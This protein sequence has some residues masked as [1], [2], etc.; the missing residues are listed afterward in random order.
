MENK[1]YIIY[2]S[3]NENYEQHC[4]EVWSDNEDEK[5]Y[6]RVDDLTEYPE[7]ATIERDLFN[8]YDFIKAVRL[9]FRI[10]QRGYDNIVVKEVPWEIFQ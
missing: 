9:G 4:Q 8:G 7:D 10:A 6:Y 2:F 5:F 3:D 1:D